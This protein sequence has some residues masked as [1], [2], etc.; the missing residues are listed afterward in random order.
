MNYWVNLFNVNTWE[1]F[2]VA[3]SKVSGF[4][5]SRRRFLKLVEPKDIFLCYV[6]GVMR[7]V[8]ALE[9]LGPSKDESLIW[10]D[11]DCPVRFDV[12]ALVKLDPIYGIPMYDLEGKVSFFQEKGDKRHFKGKIR[13]SLGTP[14]DGLD[15]EII[16]N[17]LTKNKN[18]PIEKPFDIKKF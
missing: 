14:L 17:L 5:E 3:G 6:T 15:G 12:N 1:E 13:A 11:F 18:N 2:N 4:T 10:K 8:G 9:V 7:W 16:F